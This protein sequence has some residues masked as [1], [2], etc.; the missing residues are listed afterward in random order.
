M[1]YSDLYMKTDFLYTSLAEFGTEWTSACSAL[2]NDFWLGVRMIQHYVGF[3]ASS[4]MPIQTMDLTYILPNFSNFT[5]SFG[6]RWAQCC[7]RIT[8]FGFW[9]CG[10]LLSSTHAKTPLAYSPSTHSDPAPISSD[11]CSL[12]QSAFISNI[13]IAYLSALFFRDCFAFLDFLSLNLWNRIG[14]LSATS[15]IPQL[16]V[17]PSR[18]VSQWPIRTAGFHC[19]GCPH[20]PRH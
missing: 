18:R 12:D 16:T 1:I 3:H 20:I 7:W 15:S 10:L 2:T 11:L 13:S 4:A 19:F 14:A 5:F 17:Y 9:N 6:K 8:S